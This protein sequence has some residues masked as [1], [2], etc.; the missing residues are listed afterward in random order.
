MMKRELLS[1]LILTAMMF[2]ACSDDL[3]NS[4]RYNDGLLHLKLT[5]NDPKGQWTEGSAPQTRAL[6]AI[7]MTADG[8]EG[9]TLYLHCEEQDMIE[10]SISDMPE[11]RGQRLTGEAF[12]DASLTCFGLYGEVSSEKVLGELGTPYNKILKSGF[13]YHDDTKWYESNSD[14]DLSFVSSD[15]WGSEAKGNFYAWAPFHYNGDGVDDENEAKNISV[16]MSGGVPTLTYTMQHAEADNKDILTASKLNLSRTEKDT[17]GIELQFRHVL[18]ALKF[19][20]TT[21]TG[22]EA[23][24]SGG[25]EEFSLQVNKIRVTGIYNTGTCTIG[26]DPTTWTPGATTD[27]CETN[28]IDNTTVNINTDEHCFLILPQTAPAGAKLTLDC[29]VRNSSDVVVKEHLYIQAPFPT[30]TEWKPGHSYTY[31]ISDTEL[32]HI[33]NISSSFP[34][35]PLEGGEDVF[36]VQSYY[37]NGTGYQGDGIPADWHME[38]KDENGRWVNGLPLGYVLL[39]ENNEPVLDEHL[40]NVPTK[41]PGSVTPKTYKLDALTRIEKSEII[42]QLLEHQ[43]GS[44]TEAHDLS[45]HDVTGASLP[46]GRSTA[47]CYI[48]NGYGHFK[49]PLVYGNAIKNGATNAWAYTERDEYQIFVNYLDN[50]IASPYILTDTGKGVDDLEAF[51]IW[52]DEKNLVLPS[53]VKLSGDG[54]NAFMEFAIVQPYVKS[55]NIILGLREKTGDKRILWS[56][57]IWVSARKYNETVEV[58]NGSYRL[59]FTHYN[60]G[61]R[62]PD[63]KTYAPRTTEI[64]IMQNESPEKE[65]IAVTQDGGT[66]TTSG[67]NLY[68]QHGRKD[69]M[70]AYYLENG[71]KKDMALRINGTLGYCDPEWNGRGTHGGVQCAEI[72]APAAVTPVS[73]GGAIQHPYYLYSTGAGDWMKKPGGGA[74]THANYDYAGRWDPEKA[75]NYAGNTIT[76]YT[77]RIGDAPS[78]YSHIK[79]IY[80][81]CPIGFAVPPSAAYELM[82]YNWKTSTATGTEDGL[83]YI[84]FIGPTGSLRFRETGWRVNGGGY[85]ENFNTYGYYWTAGVRDADVHQ[86]WYLRINDGDFDVYNYCRNHTEPI[87]AVRDNEDIRKH[88][89][90]PTYESPTDY[91]KYGGDVE[92]ESSLVKRK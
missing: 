27:Y 88:A 90:D 25:S 71:T 2:A 16:A 15:G 66:V 51:I 45:L 48:V 70:P 28:D 14:L 82:L 60:L 67:S 89:I 18:S 81:P 80:D 30:G 3:D 39:D 8:M 74:N 92:P 34:D 69:P 53:S 73:M 41:I 78:A 36:T 20:G 33:L 42:P 63:T 32:T 19:K 13:T 54:E 6:P 23:T 24:V 31:N 75:G 17:K 68:Y 47:N 84:D 76:S 50:H 61:W 85:V 58:S 7:P 87:R 10:T 1:G 65:D 26:A 22:L 79:T 29:E 4:Q 59:D 5:F 49:F 21:V 64:R 37:T 44:A 72:Q 56:W 40:T 12:N 57:H 11:T 9:L 52:Q 46:N 43:Y 62:V 83:D 77:D 35:F 38:Y 86:G 55:G 91:P